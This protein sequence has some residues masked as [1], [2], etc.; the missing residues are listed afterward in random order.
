MR[1]AALERHQV[2]IYLVAIGLGLGAGTAWP[3][4]APSLETLLW[5]AL[6]LL[7]Y[8]TFVQVPLLHVREA[9]G[10]RRFLAAVLLGNFVLLPLVAWALVA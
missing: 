7:L 1:R 9:F 6:A 10:D 3:A 2:W 5:P 8:A 4:V